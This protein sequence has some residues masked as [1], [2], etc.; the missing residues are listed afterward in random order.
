MPTEKLSGDSHATPIVDPSWCKGC[1][2][3]MEFCPKHVLDLADEKINIQN[4]DDCIGCG[5]C[6]SLCPDYAIWLEE[7]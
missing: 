7:V 2:I 1:G 5:I 6:E 3:C 4:I